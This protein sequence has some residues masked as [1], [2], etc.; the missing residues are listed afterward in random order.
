MNRL[1]LCITILLVSFVSNAQFKE[2]SVPGHPDKAVLMTDKTLNPSGVYHQ[3]FIHGQKF[4][5][6]IFGETVYDLQTYNAMQQRMF[7]YPD[8][9]IG[10]TW[11]LG[12]EVGIWGDRGTGYNYFDGME[13]DPYPTVRLETESTGWPCYAPLGSNGEVVCAFYFEDPYWSLVFNRREQKGE[14][15]WVEFYLSGPTEMGIAWPAIITNGENNNTIHL[16]AVTVGGE[17]MGQNGALLYSRSLDGG[18][19][20]DIEHHFFEE[21][22]PDHLTRVPGDG[23]SWA[24]PRGDT[25]AFCVGFRTEDGYIMKSYDN[26]ITWQKSIVYDSPYSPYPGG[27]T[28]T[29]GAG[30]I[31]QSIALDNQGM[32]HV[33]FGRMKYYYNNLGN[34]FYFPATEGL[35]YWNENMD[36]LDST[37][38]SS[39]TLDKLINN[40]NLIGWVIPYNGDSTLIGWGSYYVSLTS[41]PQINI[42]EQ[43]RIFVLYS[44]TAAGYDNGSKNFRHIF[45]NSSNDGGNTWNGIKD[46]CTD[47]NYLFA[48]CNYPAMSPTFINNTIHFYFE[49]D[50][51]PGLHVWTNEHNPTTNEFVYMPVEIPFLT[52]E[53]EYITH[54]NNSDGV[55]LNY[56]NPFNNYTHIEFKSKKAEI[57]QLNIYNSE[58]KQIRSTQYNC[59]KGQNRIKL[60]RDQLTQGLY[61]YTIIQNYKI[62]N[63]KFIIY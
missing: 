16:L 15:A 10:T 62:F 36:M 25:L 38:V 14:G 59:Q 8:E 51:E 60:K 1:V 55:C 43:E 13:W 34:L 63:G 56:P 47:I 49:T 52:G 31:T 61:F 46:F 22:G 45:G 48:E 28:P 19:T 7:V 17:Y 2:V 58:G 40:G 29:Y 9:T 18:E 6:A 30:D 24:D 57:I 37:I 33:T 44:A 54:E 42:D 26:G 35:I 23:Y 27:S 12:Y 11:M 4:D 53:Q 41:W 32:A 21:L 5:E 3:A 50:P 20:W 39:Y